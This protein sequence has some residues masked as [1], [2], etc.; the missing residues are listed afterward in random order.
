[1]K[2]FWL[3]LLLLAAVSALGLAGTQVLGQDKK[4]DGPEVGQPAPD[5]AL[6][7]AT[8]DSV[9]FKPE[10]FVKLSALK[11]SNVILAFY[12]ADWSGGCTTEVCS[13]RDGWG[14]L[15][16]LNAKLLAISGDYVFSHKEW[17]A[18]HKLTFQLLADHDHAVG[19]LYASFN[20]QYFGGINSRTIY[21]VDKDGI[22]RYRNLKF[23]PDPKAGDYDKLRAELAKLQG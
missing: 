21:L 10:E 15:A 6:P 4:A 17:A 14:D 20:P 19:K 11:G 23:N 22:V 12:P 8:A 7:W 5:F 2:R 16:K 9:H 1:M 13:F 18:H 3:K